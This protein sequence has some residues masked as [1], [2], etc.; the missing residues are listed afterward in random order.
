M[1]ETS[2]TGKSRETQGRFIPA[3]GREGWRLG[4]T[5]ESVGDLG[6]M[7]GFWQRVVTD[8]Q[9]GEYTENY[10]KVYFKMVNWGRLGGSAC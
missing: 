4:V 3:R 9:P 6:M 10:W 7:K 2:R 8:A 5:T 1:Y